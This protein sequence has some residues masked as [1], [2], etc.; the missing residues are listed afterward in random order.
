PSPEASPSP[1]PA[2]PSPENTTS[3]GTLPATGIPGFPIG[4]SEQQVVDRLGQPLK[5]RDGYWPNTEAARYDLLPGQV[6]LGYIYDRGTRRLRQTEVAF[7]QSVDSLVM[8]TTLNGLLEGRT[9]PEI[10]TGLQEIYT[11]QASRYPFQ[12]GN[13][14]GIIERNGS[15]RIYIAVWDTDLH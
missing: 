9:T 4:T 1:A 11:R 10:E 8:R 7:A 15:D 2:S 6:T 13:L 12:I 3:P 5:L 14:E